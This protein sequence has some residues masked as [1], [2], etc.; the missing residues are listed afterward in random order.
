MYNHIAIVKLLL[1][2]GH[3][4]R[5]LQLKSSTRL[6]QG[7]GYTA[8]LYAA[9][10]GHELAELLLGADDSHEHLL[11][12]QTYTKMNALEFAA[13]KASVLVEFAEIHRRIVKLLLEYHVRHPV[14]KWK[15]GA[16]L[17][18]KIRREVQEEHLD[19]IRRLASRE[20]IGLHS[21]IPHK[22][23]EKLVYDYLQPKVTR[24]LVPHQK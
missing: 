9:A 11:K 10:Q 1:S 15:R 13:N 23:A 14:H 8:L 21:F 4:A 17:I 16:Q 7:D 5:L 19:R 22:N 24:R 3:G 2:Y 18:E 20:H 6:A 12:R